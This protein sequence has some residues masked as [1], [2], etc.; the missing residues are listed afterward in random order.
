[1]VAPQETAE[2]AEQLI[3]ETVATHNIPPNTLTPHA[4]RGPA[5][6]SQAGGGLAG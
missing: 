6:E 2:L 5:C 4:D 1:M 3:A